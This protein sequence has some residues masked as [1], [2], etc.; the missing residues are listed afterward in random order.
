MDN[1]IVIRAEHLFKE[2]KL[3]DKKSDRVR[4]A[5]SLTRKKYY[6]PFVALNDISFDV[7]RGETVGIIGT[8][9]SG[10]STLLKILT[11]V[12]APTSGSFEVNGKISALLELGTGFNPE[13]TGYENIN[14]QGTLMGYSREEM[15]ERREEIIRFADIGDYL[16]QP[17]KNYSSGMF[18]RL[19][20]AVAISVNPDILIVDETLSVGD[21]FFQNKCFH[22]FD[23]LQASGT[24]ILFVSHDTATVQKMCSRVL[25]IERGKQIMLGD[26]YEVCTAYFNQRIE[27]LNQ[28]NEELVN[29]M[30]TEAND[31][32]EKKK[33]SAAVPKIQIQSDS[34][35]SEKAEIVSCYI[36][37]S[38]GNIVLDLSADETYTLCIISRFDEEISNAIIGFV[39]ENRKGVQFISGNTYADAGLQLHLEKGSYL[40]TTFTFKMPRI[41]S[42]EYLISPAIAVG[43]QDAHV[44]LT[45]VHGAIMINVTRKGYEI[46]EFGLEFEITDRILDEVT[47]LNNQ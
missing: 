31:A 2:Y 20:F 24:S 30:E 38:Q 12:I 25:W 21:V 6:R 36:R 46:S 14:L 10:K 17:V 44:N 11:G 42:G 33:V 5:L 29:A 40:E 34:R 23:E 45:W 1:D 9:G 22:K 4:E 32:L 35:T 27:R 19:A 15:D 26:S 28:Q 18:A 3:Y 7:K 13:Y 43:T 47:F 39:L 16:N 8:N 37:D 41:R